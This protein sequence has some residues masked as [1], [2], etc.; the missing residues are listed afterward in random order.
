MNATEIHHDDAT[1]DAS[2]FLQLN[3]AFWRGES[4]CQSISG[5]GQGHETGGYVMVATEC[6]LN[7]QHPLDEPGFHLFDRFEMQ[8]MIEA[9]AG[10]LVTQPGCR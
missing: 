2:F 9:L 10:Q 5:D 8:E 1:F 6:I 3:R 4:G 7:D